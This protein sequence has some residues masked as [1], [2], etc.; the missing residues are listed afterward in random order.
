VDENGKVTYVTE[1]ELRALH[2][3]IS[4]DPQPYSNVV[5]YHSFKRKDGKPLKP[6]KVTELVFDLLPTSYLFKKGHSIRIALA[7][8]DKDH[9][10]PSAFAPPVLKYYRDQE[11]SSHVTLP[12][13]KR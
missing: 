12:V 3:K 8:A 9:F 6:G 1:G 7:S 13:I 11:H 5:P 10:A 2:R 4:E